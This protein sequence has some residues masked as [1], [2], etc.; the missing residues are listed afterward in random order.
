MTK[1]HPQCEA[2][3]ESPQR[4]IP[5]EDA[6]SHLRIPEKYL[7]AETIVPST[8]IIETVFGCNASCTMCPINMPTERKKGIIDPQLFRDIID[9]LAVYKQ[10]IKQ[11]DLFGVG[12]PLLDPEY[13]DKIAYAKSKG[14]LN[15]GFA[16][17]AELLTSEM[18]SKVLGAGVDTIMVSIDGATKETHESIRIKTNF[19]NVVQNTRN[20]IEQRDKLGYSTKFVLRF[21][22]QEINIH[23]WDTFC[24]F[25]KKIINESCGDLIIGYDLHSWGGE[26]EVTKREQ[27]SIIPKD[28]PCHHLF[29]RMIIL[30][31]GTIP[32]CCADMHLANKTIGNCSTDNPIEVFNST[33]M[34]HFRDIHLSSKR[35]E[36][37]ICR[38]CTILDSEA[39]KDKLKT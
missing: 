34:K 10:E 18:A 12:E 27:S 24:A 16:T 2:K 17:N 9:K 36:M 39:K 15:V 28:L 11:L 7:I 6:I 26:I 13:P 30:R 21:I 38:A 25:W 14:F 35:L 23:E 33:M 29:D 22:R 32:L 5:A 19:S 37:D 4:S 1:F 3:Q 20:A 31:D 8:V